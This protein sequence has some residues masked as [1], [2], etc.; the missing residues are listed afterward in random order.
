MVPTCGPRRW[1]RASPAR[2]ATPR[3]PRRCSRAD[4]N[5]ACV[6]GAATVHCLRGRSPLDCHEAARRERRGEPGRLWWPRAAL[7][8]CA[9][10][11]EIVTSCSRRT[12]R[13]TRCDTGATPMVVACEKGHLGIELL[14][15]R[16]PPLLHHQRDTRRRSVAIFHHTQPPRSSPSSAAAAVRGCGGRSTL[17]ARGEGGAMARRRWRR[18]RRLIAA[19]LVDAP[20]PGGRVRLRRVVRSTTGRRGRRAAGGHHEGERARATRG[21]RVRD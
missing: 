17:E 15:S 20:P 3:S 9:R 11:T 16:R 10:Y 18:R 4:V 14:S 2:R 1:R 21:G 13:W 8:A 7:H 19:A 5:Q 6:D 12:P